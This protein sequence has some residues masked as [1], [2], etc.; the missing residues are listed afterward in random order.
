M[1]HLVVDDDSTRICHESSFYDEPGN[2]KNE[3]DTYNVKSF[4]IELLV[5]TLSTCFL[6][7]DT[8]CNVSFFL[9]IF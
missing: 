5:D 3:Q 8:G 1:R 2:S 4:I 9:G 7:C 6:A